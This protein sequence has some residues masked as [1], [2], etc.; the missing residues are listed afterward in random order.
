M[1]ESN[2]AEFAQ[3]GD[4]YFIKCGI[5]SFCHQLSLSVIKTNERFSAGILRRAR[6]A[7]STSR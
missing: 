5:E 6:M 7:R 1:M 2:L 3:N 4:S